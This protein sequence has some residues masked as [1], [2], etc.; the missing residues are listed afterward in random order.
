MATSVVRGLG[1]PEG[2]IEAP[3]GTFYINTQSSSVFVKVKGEATNNKGWKGIN[4]KGYYENDNDNGIMMNNFK[5]GTGRIYV[6][7]TYY[8]VYVSLL[9][10]ALLSKTFN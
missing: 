9:K 6:C 7:H 5:H 4:T 2:F 3:R 10:E 8:H 1:S